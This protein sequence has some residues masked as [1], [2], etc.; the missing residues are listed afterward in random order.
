MST[1][2]RSAPHSAPHASGHVA[3]ALEAFVAIVSRDL[4]V[5]RRE[6]LSF[7]VQTLVQP[8]FFLFVF[9][10]VL[11]G[12]GVASAGFSVLLLPGIVA[13]TAFVTPLQSVATDLGRDLGFTREIDDRLL[14]PLPTYLVAVEKMLLA[15]LRGLFA[16]ALV[17]P[18]AALILGSGYEVRTDAVGPLIGLLML[19]AML[20]ASLGL[21]LGTLVPLTRLPLLFSLVVTPLL[22]TGC[23]YYPW[24]ALG[25]VRWFQV[26]TLLNPLTYAAEGLR[27]AMMPPSRFSTLATGLVLAAL[28][29]ALVASLAWGLRQFQR[30]VIR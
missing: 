29:A 3:V 6:A 16:A 15:T 9:G 28:V 10:R 30:R 24:A 18:C 12:I 23:T 1:S 8:V 4:L 20:G 19:T 5:T 13:F 25:G 27:W 21:L 2:T 14:A 17:F 26:L 22:F 11:T 7:V